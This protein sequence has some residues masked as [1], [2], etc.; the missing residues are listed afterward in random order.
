MKKEKIY[1][2][3]IDN[4]L[5]DEKRR[6]IEK[7]IHKTALA[8]DTPLK[9]AWGPDPRILR[10][11]ADPVHIEVRFHARRVELLAAAPLWARLLFTDAKKAE[12]KD[13]IEN[14]LV[15]ARLRAP[16]ETA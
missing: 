6:V 14:V 7:H 11:T 8:S 1:E 13:T 3:A 4:P 5:T 2:F 15:S 9:Y 12:L 10:I 16:E